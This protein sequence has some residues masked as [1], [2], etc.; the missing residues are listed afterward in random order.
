MARTAEPAWSRLAR[1]YDWQLVLE[2]R[3]LGTLLAMLAITESD[4][5][6][7]VGTGT[8]AVLRQLREH[9]A[10]PARVVGIDPSSEMLS[11]AERAVGPET[12]LVRAHATA[13]PFVDASF[14][15]ATCAYLLHL[16]ERPERAAV[17]REI[18]RVLTPGGRLGLVTIAPPIGRLS[19]AASWPLRAVARRSR[20]AAA[21][22]RPLDPRGELE[23]PFEVKATRRVAFGYPSLCV[24]AR[25]R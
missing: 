3:P 7:D 10:R 20:G 14:D 21:G 18:E 4:R 1:I 9:G 13:L 12:E 11:R 25:R 6:L 22:L 24:A 17:L 16:L 19:R 23:P 5:L 2:R 8:G 15:V